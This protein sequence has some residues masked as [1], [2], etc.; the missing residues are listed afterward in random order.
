MKASLRNLC[1]ATGLVAVSA[2]AIAA[3]PQKS[4][5][6][7][8]ANLQAAHKVALQQ[9]KPILIVFG[10]EWCTF[11]KKLESQTLGNPQLAGYINQNFVAVHIDLD[12]EPKVGE[13]LEVKKLPCT[14]I[15]TPSADLLG[16]F[17]GF[18][19][20]KQY[21]Q[22]ISGAQKLHQEVLQAAGQK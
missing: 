19:E 8:Q 3:G 21:F 15:L 1:L 17:E 11:C 13:I 9:N 2:F 12:E 18:C 7:W 20:P 4:P 6:T 5:V 22:K 14:V 10:A 16:R